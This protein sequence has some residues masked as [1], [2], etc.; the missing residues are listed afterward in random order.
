MDYLGFF[1]YEQRTN[2]FFKEQEILTM[3]LNLN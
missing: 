2:L 3:A 1:G